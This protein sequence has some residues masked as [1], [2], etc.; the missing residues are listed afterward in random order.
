MDIGRV[1]KDSWVIFTKDWGVLV[2]GALIAVV[3]SFV[4]LGI[5]GLALSGGVYLMVLR[6]VREGRKPEVR[7]VFACFDRLWAFVLAYLLLL[8]IALAFV[9]V[10]LTPFLALTLP[11]SGARAFGV[12]LT[13]LAGFGAAI[14]AA[15]LSTVWVYVLLLMADRRIGVVEALGA[16]REMVGRSGFWITFLTLL[17]IGFIAGAVNGLLGSVT[18]GIGGLVA[19]VVVVPWELAAY[20]SMYLQAG[21]EGGLLPSGFPGPSAAWQGGVVYAWSFQGWQPGWGAGF[22]PYAPPAGPGQ[23]SAPGPAP[24]GPPVYG[25]PNGPTGAVAPFG[26]LPGPGWVP[27]PSPYGPPSS[28]P[29][30]GPPPAAAPYAAPPGLAG[31]PPGFAP[32]GPQQ[33]PAT[34]RPAGPPTTPPPAAAP[35]TQSQP[36]PDPRAGEL[37]SWSR[38]Q[39]PGPPPTPPG[40]APQPPAPPRT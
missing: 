2:M 14:V 39:P 33:E 15:Y 30:F 5:L 1:L 23:Y 13:A 4:T 28:A 38:S 35:A 27:Y 32:S 6:R 40:P 31:S 17:V 3:L 16:S 20:A 11:D 22:A 36:T 19:S 25:P 10:V 9:A 8:G 7:D 24:W 26:P 29:P 18:L 34:Q 12:F 37:P 21:G